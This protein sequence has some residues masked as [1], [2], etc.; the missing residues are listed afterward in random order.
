VIV[1]YIYSNRPED[2]IRVQLRLRNIADAI[3]RTGFHRANV[4]DIDS[5]VENTSD[6]QRVCARSDILIIYRYL[7]GPVLT[8]IQYWKARE[9][10]VIV[11]F[12]QA[13]NCLTPDMPDYPFWLE[14]LPLMSTAG[15]NPLESQIDPIPLEQFKWGLGMVDA[16]T[17][18]S[19][20][21]TDDWSQYTNVYELPDYLNTCQYPVLDQARDEEIWIGL[22]YTI[23]YDSFKNS[24]LATAMEHI[25]RE[26]P[27]VRLVLCNQ[28][29]KTDIDLDIDREQIVAYSPRSFEEWVNL[30]LNLDIGL[31]PVYSDFD[32]RLSPVNLLE[33]M[34]VKIPWIATRQFA[35]HDLSRYGRW[36][37]NSPEAWKGAILKVVEQ[38]DFYQK[39]AR[40]EPFLYAFG[41]DAGA[42]ID[43]ALRIYSAIVNQ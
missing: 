35:F 3:N 19:A 40:G 18:A 37:Q 41:Q 15:E 14:G 39:K 10:R 28:G 25:C 43:K 36:V 23:Q 5:F 33:F 2:Q 16:A 38:L 17:V 29:K 1:T 42:N 7:Y 11:D 8:A 20:R 31:A 30:L 6:A 12:D 13:I 4:L 9:K 22:G 26:Y 21:L 24:G 27:Q 34:I 32:L